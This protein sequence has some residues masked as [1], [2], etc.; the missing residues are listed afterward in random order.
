MIKYEVEKL[1]GLSKQRSEEQAI[2][3]KNISDNI[4]Q[5]DVEYL[6]DALAAME[7]DH[8][9]RES[10]AVLNPNPFKHHQKQTL[11]SL[12]NDQLRYIIILAKNLQ[13]IINASIEL[14]KAEKGSSELNKIFGI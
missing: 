8:S 5:I 12:K 11:N 13:K 9:F 1:M 7:K 6:E 3:I 10:A 2:L 4:I 14:G